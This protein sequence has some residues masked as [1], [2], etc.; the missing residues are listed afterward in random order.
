MPGSVARGGNRPIFK[1]FKVYFWKTS[2]CL[3]VSLN[4]S[5][6][7]TEVIRQ[8]IDAYLN[9]NEVDHSLLKYPKHPEGTIK[10]D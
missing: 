4:I 1:E 8:I 7:G 9:S 2:L 6:T 3:N 5:A 10:H